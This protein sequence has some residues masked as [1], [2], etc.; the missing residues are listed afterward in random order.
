VVFD[1]GKVLL[2]FDYNLAA[3]GLSP[4]SALPAVE[5]RRVLDQSPL[6]H[7]YES[8]QLTTEEFQAE[9]RRVTGYHGPAEHF[10]ES[11]GAIFTEIPSMIALHGELRARGV[12]TFIFSNTNELAVGHIRRQFT[13][14]AGFDGYIFSHEIGCMKPAAA[15]YDAVEKLTGR[16]GAELIYLD[17][18]PENVAGAA[19]RGWQAVL[20][21]APE[22][23]R[24]TVASLLDW[25]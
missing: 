21:V 14:F 17:D 22:A 5:F 2:D 1:L 20:H 18:R 7:Q 23:T 16:R 12:P 6:L 10:R 25:S 13:F 4:F 19:S 24:A 8:G 3:R 11:F 9:V 15:S